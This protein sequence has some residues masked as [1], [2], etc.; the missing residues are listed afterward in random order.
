MK[1]DAVQSLA[2]S[3]TRA[4]G[5]RGYQQLRVATA[6]LLGRR[7]LALED[8]V[9]HYLVGNVLRWKCL[10]MGDARPLNKD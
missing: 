4:R 7:G 3:T 2:R 6:W 5:S 8:P 10:S 1:R 9:Q